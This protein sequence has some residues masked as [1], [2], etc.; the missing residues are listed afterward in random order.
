MCKNSKISSTGNN[1][2]FCVTCLTRWTNRDYLSIICHTW[3]WSS[4]DSRK[5]LVFRGTPLLNINLSQLMPTVTPYGVSS[6][7]G[8]KNF[9]FTYWCQV[10]LKDWDKNCTLSPAFKHLIMIVN[11]LFLTWHALVMADILSFLMSQQL[12]WSVHFVFPWFILFILALCVLLNVDVLY[13]SS[14]N[15]LIECR[16]WFF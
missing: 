15:G 7:G 5:S 8:I 9:C 2:V 13:M 10:S 3:C 4:S 1:I 11:G 12:I 16:N 6:L 14:I